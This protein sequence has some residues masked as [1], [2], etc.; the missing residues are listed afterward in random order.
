M[1]ILVIA[2]LHGLNVWE[3]F[4]NKD[5]FDRIIFLWDYVDSFDVPD[6]D[7]FE[8]LRNIIQF[9]KDN[10]EKV[11][12]LLWNHDIQYIWEWNWCSW[13]R[14]SMATW[15]KILFEENLDLFK[16]F[17]EEQWYLFS[18]AWI[19]SRWEKYNMNI[20]DEYFCDGFYSYEQLNML[21]ETHN[22]KILFQCSSSRWWFD[23]YSWPLWA[24][25]GDTTE[26][27][28]ISWYKQVVWHTK[29]PSKVMLPHI[30]YCDC[31]EHW[32]WQPLIIDTEDERIPEENS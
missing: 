18:H 5:N 23:K 32:N 30:I 21:L 31:L 3:K 19:D 25:K 26:H 28:I 9:K 12:L 27:W 13:Y 4:V 11:V 22:R 7:I 10:P 17:H 29:V 6:S 14:P 8:N 1:K 15:L 16:V 20:I 2:D 24:D